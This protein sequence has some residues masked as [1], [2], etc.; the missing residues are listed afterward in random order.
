MQ[1]QGLGIDVEGVAIVSNLE[2]SNIP[3]DAILF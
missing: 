2:H 3:E 1:V